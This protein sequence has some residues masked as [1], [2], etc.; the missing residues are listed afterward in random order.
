MAPLKVL[1]ADAQ[2]LTRAGLKYLLES[3]K[4]IAVAGEVSERS[5]LLKQIKTVRPDLLIIDYKFLS[6]FDV[7]DLFLI[8]ETSPATEVIAISSDSDKVSILKVLETGIKAFLTKECSTEEIINAV[9]AAARGEK[10]FCNKVF[11]ILMEKHLD[12]EEQDCTPTKLTVRE[13]QVLKLIAEGNSTLQIAKELH[14]SPH[15][16]NTHRKNMIRK[17]GIKSPTEFVMY[18]IDMGIIRTS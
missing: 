4:D 6:N 10:F 1:L 16:I 7:E 15:T 17:L 18:A 5:A 9:Y 13:T 2:P 11:D 8:K 3:R 14:L 12:K